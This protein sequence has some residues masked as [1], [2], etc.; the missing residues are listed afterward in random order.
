MVLAIVMKQIPAFI[1]LCSLTSCMSGVNLWPTPQQPRYTWQEPMQ[2]QPA[3]Y[4]Y[5]SNEQRQADLRA[6]IA[7]EDLQNKREAILKLKLDKWAE[8]GRHHLGIPNAAQLCPMPNSM[9]I[10]NGKFDD[11]YTVEDVVIQ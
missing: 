6:Q 7:R 10:I 9:D 3:S 11:Q 1:A 5:K 8:C 2:Q 4:V